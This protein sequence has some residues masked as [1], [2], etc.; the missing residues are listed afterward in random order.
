MQSPWQSQWYACAIAHVKP[1]I[2]VELASSYGSV[3]IA[4]ESLSLADVADAQK[5]CELVKRKR[6]EAGIKVPWEG[7]YPKLFL[8]SHKRMLEVKL[9]DIA[10]LTKL[11]CRLVALI[12][13]LVG[14]DFDPDTLI[15]TFATLKRPIEVMLGKDGLPQYAFAGQFDEVNRQVFELNVI[16]QLQL[17]SYI[18]QLRQC[19]MNG[20]RQGSVGIAP[21]RGLDGE[22]MDQVVALLAGDHKEAAFKFALERAPLYI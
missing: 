1:K 6:I 16:E 5:V 15:R 4:E 18:R 20:A 2:N 10:D 7:V 21:P 12:T 8:E 9:I 22:N 13:Q 14:C 19:L 17:A 11:L 3:E